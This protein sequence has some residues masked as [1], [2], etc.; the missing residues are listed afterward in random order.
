MNV[1]YL[2]GRNNLFLDIIIYLD[3]VMLYMSFVYRR[4]VRMGSRVEKE[5]RYRVVVYEFLFFCEVVFFFFLKLGIL[6]VI[7]LFYF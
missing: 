4:K 2:D 1:Y 5:R 7:C 6:F 3:N